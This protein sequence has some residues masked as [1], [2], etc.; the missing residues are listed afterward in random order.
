MNDPKECIQILENLCVESEPGQEARLD[1]DEL[2]A[3]LYAI[4]YMKKHSGEDYSRSCFKCKYRNAN[5]G[6]PKT[7]TFWCE[8]KHYLTGAYSHCDNFESS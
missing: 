5:I 1:A 8:K 2:D 3:V 4:K 6:N 7:E